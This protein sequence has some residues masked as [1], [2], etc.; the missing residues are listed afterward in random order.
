[1]ISTLRLEELRLLIISEGERW[2]IEPH[3]ALLRAAWE[4]PAQ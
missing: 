4:G 3:P 2:L 1:M